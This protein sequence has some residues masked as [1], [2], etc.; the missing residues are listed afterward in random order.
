MARK[1]CQ[2]TAGAIPGQTKARLRTRARCSSRAGEQ[3]WLGRQN[4]I[5]IRN[6]LNASDDS[7]VPSGTDVDE[8]EER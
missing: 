4:P 8:E 2:P 1:T 3:G 7:P 5:S 6:V